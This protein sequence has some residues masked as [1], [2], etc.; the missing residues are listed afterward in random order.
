MSSKEADFDIKQAQPTEYVSGCNVSELGFQVC[1]GSWTDESVE[2]R[3]G[4]SYT[5]L[6][7]AGESRGCR[8]VQAKRP[9]G[10]QRQ[11]Q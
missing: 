7:M 3:S 4:K 2:E 10:G 6:Q 1:K 5:R 11:V 8:M 9:P